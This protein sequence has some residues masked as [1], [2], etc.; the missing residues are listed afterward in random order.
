MYKICLSIGLLMSFVIGDV[1]HAAATIP[2]DCDTNAMVFCGAATQAELLTKLAQGDSKHSGA[3]LVAMYREQGIT[4]SEIATTVPGIAMKDGRILVNNKVVATKAVS[5]GRLQ[6]SGS[7]KDGSLWRSPNQ[8]AFLA[9]SITALVEMKHGQFQWAVLTSCGNSVFATPVIVPTP[10]PT[11]VATPSSTPVPTPLPTPTPTPTP[12]PLPATG[13][14]APVAGALGLTG[15]GM[16]ARTYYR[17]RRQ[18][19]M[20]LRQRVDK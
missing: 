8:T 5:D 19:V 10:T 7:V 16:A 15:M 1:A 4:P 2:R 17:G 13:P 3:S 14:V 20:Q 6:L 18:L 12:V 9:D 11:P